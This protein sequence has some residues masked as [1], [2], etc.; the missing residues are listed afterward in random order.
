MKKQFYSKQTKIFMDL[1]TF[2]CNFRTLIKEEKINKIK[3]SEKQTYK[4][5]TK[6]LKVKKNSFDIRL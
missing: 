3:D 1:K 5:K 6:Y 2:R 4:C